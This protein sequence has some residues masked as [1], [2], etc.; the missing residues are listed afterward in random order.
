MI[1]EAFKRCE[2]NKVWGLIEGEWVHIKQEYIDHHKPQEGHEVLEHP[3]A[4]VLETK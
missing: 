2:L 3:S 1:I 4:P